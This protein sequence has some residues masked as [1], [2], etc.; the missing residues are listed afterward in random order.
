MGRGAVPAGLWKKGLRAVP[1]G[2]WKKGRHAMG[3]RGARRHAREE[4]AGK[5]ARAGRREK[6]AARER[7]ACGGREGDGMGGDGGTADPQDSTR[8]FP[9]AISRSLGVSIRA[10]T[11]GR[12]EET[13]SFDFLLF[14][15]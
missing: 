3:K 8:V 2:L 12:L 4:R 11:S 5:K 7:G 9:T 1:A 15:H 14:L 13:K 10:R 6:A